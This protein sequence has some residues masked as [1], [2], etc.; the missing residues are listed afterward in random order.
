MSV[1]S[2]L[3]DS[4]NIQGLTSRISGYFPR[5]LFVLPH[6]TLISIILATYPYPSSVGMAEGSPPAQ[7]A[8]GSVPWQANMQGIQNLMGFVYVSTAFGSISHTH[9]PVYQRGRP[10][11]YFALYTS[12]F[13]RTSPHSTP[14]RVFGPVLLRPTYPHPARPDILPSFGSRDPSKFPRER[15]LPLSWSCSICCNTSRSHPSITL[16]FR[17][18]VPS[19]GEM[20]AE[21]CVM[22]V[23]AGF[24]DILPELIVGQS[25]NG[26]H[27][28]TCSPTFS[29]ERHHSKSFR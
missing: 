23:E 16:Y 4:R 8:E 14:G 3:L 1:E 6:V 12:P 13:P 24:D 7:A 20:V 15:G 19:F 9:L 11:P 27:G 29:R 25:W 18:C 5:L 21:I 22:D 28:H 26:L 17:L 2:L 10:Q